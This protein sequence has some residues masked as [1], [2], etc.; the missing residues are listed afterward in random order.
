MSLADESFPVTRSNTRLVFS[1]TIPFAFP[2]LRVPV[3]F[4]FLAP[5]VLILPSKYAK[6]DRLACVEGV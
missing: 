1:G 5:V 2:F 6:I 3:I 4:D